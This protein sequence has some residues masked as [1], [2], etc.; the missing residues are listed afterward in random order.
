VSG[1]DTL[2]R[3]VFLLAYHLHWPVDSIIALPVGDRRAYLELL[4]EQLRQEAD[5]MKAARE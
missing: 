2:R 1:Q 4:T 3:E 5:A